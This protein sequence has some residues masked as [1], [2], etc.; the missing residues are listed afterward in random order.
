[1]RPTTWPADVVGV[2]GAVA[3]LGAVG[4]TGLGLD[5]ETG[6]AVGWDPDDVLVPEDGD[7]LA[8]VGVDEPAPAEELD[9]DFGETALVAVDRVPLAAVVEED[10]G[11]LAVPAPCP[12]TGRVFEASREGLGEP[13]PTER[14]KPTTK[15]T[16]ARAP[17]NAA[18]TN[19]ARLDQRNGCYPPQLIRKLDFP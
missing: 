14:T 13:P 3:P 1:M 11:P 9:G 6:A 4:T 2:V 7:E 16:T 18:P 5:H 8:V 15:P 17:I 10:P 12:A 19:L